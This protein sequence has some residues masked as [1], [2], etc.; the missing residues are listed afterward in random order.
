MRRSNIAAF[1]LVVLVI[2]GCGSCEMPQDCDNDDD[3]CSQPNPAY[4]CS[5]GACVYNYYLTSDQEIYNSRV[6]HCLHLDGN[7]GNSSGCDS[8]LPI[9]PDGVFLGVPEY[10]QQCQSWCWAASIAMVA[11]YYGHYV[12]ECE[13]AGYKSGY[14]DQCCSY[15]ACSSPCNQTATPQ[16]IKYML[17]QIGL[18]GTYVPRALS[19]TE[20][21][22]ELSSG[23]P[24]YTMFQ[25]SFSGHAVVITGFDGGGYPTYYHVVD[26]Y[27]GVQEIPYDSIL[28]G[29]YGEHWTYTIT[30][31]SAYAD[32]C[33]PYFNPEC[34]AC[35]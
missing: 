28:W 19:E 35:H 21:Q 7:G 4:T 18:Y 29:P 1:M 22:I 26:P 33:N 17:N 20:L 23:R 25:G 30:R 12:S 27:Y 3:C 5:Q 24:V 10:W 15:Y 13:L 2:L 11:D 16:E 32:G 9:N 8:D 31:L 6:Q 34:A 14:G